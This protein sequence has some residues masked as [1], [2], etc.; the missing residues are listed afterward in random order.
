MFL[1]KFALFLPKRLRLLSREKQTPKTGSH[2]SRR[3]RKENGKSDALLKLLVLAFFFVPSFFSFFRATGCKGKSE[4]TK[5]ASIQD[6]LCV[7]MVPVQMHN[8]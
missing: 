1:F 7:A 5:Q 4:K 8:P 3:C 6:L 2:G